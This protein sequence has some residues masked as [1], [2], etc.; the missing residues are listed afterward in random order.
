[1]KI[2]RTQ[3]INHVQGNIRLWTRYVIRTKKMWTI[4][5]HKQQSPSCEETTAVK[6]QYEITLQHN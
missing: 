3:K 4:C 6:F 2:K 5:T 1:M